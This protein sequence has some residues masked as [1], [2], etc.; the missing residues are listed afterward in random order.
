MKRLPS[1]VTPLLMASAIALPLIYSSGV[2]DFTRWPRLLLLQ[3]VTFVLAILWMLMRWHKEEALPPIVPSLAAFTLWQLISML[4][5]DNKVEALHRGSQAFAIAAFAMLCAFL[6]SEHGI[7]RIVQVVAIVTASVSGIAICQYWGIAF[8][9]IPTAGNPS[10]TFG[11]RNYLATYL[12]VSLPPIVAVG[13][14]ETKRSVRYLMIGAA[15]AGLSALLCTRTRGA[16]VALLT[17]AAFWVVSE[18]VR[19]RRLMLPSLRDLALV[20]GGILVALWI[21]LQAPSISN[22]GQFRIDEHKAEASTAIRT[23]FLP[24]ASRGR[25]IM[26]RNTLSMVADHPI[27]GVGLG[28]WQYAYPSY[29]QGDRITRNVAPQRPH[30]DPLWILSETGLFGLALYG[31][32]LWT[33]CRLGLVGDGENQSVATALALGVIGYAIHG[34]FSYPMERV[35]SS[36]LAGFCIGGLGALST[37]SSGP[38]YRWARLTPALAVLLALSAIL[39]IQRLQFDR[40]YAKA[41]EAWHRQ[42]WPSV[43]QAAAKALKHGPHDFRIYQ[44]QG[45]G[46]QKLGKLHEAREAFETSLRYHPN[47][48]HLPLADL[49]AEM[50]DLNMSIVHY[51][52]EIDLLPRSIQ[53]N[54]GLARTLMSK[55]DWEGAEA[56]ARIASDLDPNNPDPNLIIAEVRERQ[57]D[58]VGARSTYQQLLASRAATPQLYGRYGAL[59]SRGGKHQ[60]ALTAYRRAVDLDP[61][62]PRNHNNL[63]A[64]YARLGQHAS[65]AASYRR[66]VELD[67]TYARAWRNLADALEKDGNTS[68]AIEAYRSFLEHWTG[69][70][71][72]RVWVEARIKVLEQGQARP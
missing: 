58:L 69:E 64:G 46:L 26:W 59:L 22:T 7:R 61:D 1:L 3:T 68:A 53:A 43:T 36:A 45:A 72:H 49:L 40:D 66:A 52:R 20:G 16:W 11:Y 19:R 60:E 47:E 67:P 13:S 44:L 56:S 25:T 23:A 14:R 34:L 37:S 71:E 32:L 50:G 6:L 31:W 35:A 21:G 38:T 42:D 57:R 29:D 41:I 4:W 54:L 28:G 24:E 8:D 30:N 39:T 9:Q 48:G 70:S 65:S 17:V 18:V 10:A 27:L 33:V 62:D 63:G 51:Q 15:L 2:F 55:G 5:A 12:L